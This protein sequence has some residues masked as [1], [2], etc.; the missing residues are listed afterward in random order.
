VGLALARQLLV[1]QLLEPVVVVV[2]TE[3]KI[4]RVLQVPAV[5][6]VLPLVRGFPARVILVVVAAQVPLL[7]AVPVARAL[8]FSVY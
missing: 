3:I 1:A 8:S 5:V 7:A 4:Q 2:S 6:P